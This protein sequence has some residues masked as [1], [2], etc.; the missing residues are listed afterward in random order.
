M[1]LG[2]IAAASV[3][4]AQPAVTAVP[5]PVATPPID[6]AWAAYDDAFARAAKG[7][8]DG[9]HTGLAELVKRWP[10]HPASAR[11]QALLAVV[12]ARVQ[13]AND[14]DRPSKVARGELVFWQTVGG[15]SLG[16]NGCQLL[17]CS[18]ARETAAVYMAT[19]GG[20][21]ALSLVATRRGIRNG[22]AQLYNS[23]Q[24]WGAWNGLLLNDGFAEDRDEAAVA[25]ATQLG[26]LGAGIGLWQ[27]WRPTAGDVAL[28]NTFLVWGTVLTLWGHLSADEAPALRTIV[29]AGDVAIVAGALV[30]RQ[31]K[32]SRGRTLLIDVGGILG[33]MAGGLVAVG[34]ESSGSEAS[35]GVPFL[36]GTAVGLGIAAAATQNWDAPPLPV[37]VAPTVVTGPN[38]STGWGLH[39]GFTF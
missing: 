16:A 24:T 11:A 20:S 28:T 39:A 19:V 34:T 18:T 30:S 10:D 38:R 17:D 29:I 15:I 25:I 6:V 36:L 9:A 7:D 4:S 13:R 26:G 23:A 22:E 2:L 12:A 8:L 5:P 35:V 21:L 3:A 27:V 14:P 33:T 1:V 32:M 31:V 37:Q